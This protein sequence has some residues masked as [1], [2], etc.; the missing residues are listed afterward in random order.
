MMLQHHIAGDLSAFVGSDGINLSG[1]SQH[2][3]ERRKKW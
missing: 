3:T 1:A 2:A